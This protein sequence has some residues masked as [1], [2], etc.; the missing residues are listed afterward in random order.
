MGTVLTDE[1]ISFGSLGHWLLT[2]IQ[3]QARA[4]GSGWDLDRRIAKECIPGRQTKAQ[5]EVNGKGSRR[6]CGE[7]VW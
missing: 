4:L 6:G 1:L 5:G 7:R 2:K 3:E